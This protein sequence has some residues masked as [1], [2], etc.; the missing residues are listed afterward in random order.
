M[1][2]WKAYAGAQLWSRFFPQ[3]RSTAPTK[4]CLPGFLSNMSRPTYHPIN[5]STKYVTTISCRCRGN[6][7][8]HVKNN[9]MRDVKSITLVIVSC[10]IL[11]NRRKSNIQVC[12]FAG[13]GWNQGKNSVTFFCCPFGPRYY[14]AARNLEII[15]QG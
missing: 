10:Y 14:S 8:S 13:D 3:N 4:N 11:H 12:N 9:A 1:I 7:Y 2:L 5:K 15:L 6:S